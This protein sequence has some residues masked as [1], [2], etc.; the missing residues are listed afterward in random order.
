MNQKQLVKPSAYT[1]RNL[2]EFRNSASDGK[3]ILSFNNTQ[4]Y[5][6]LWS[7]Q[8]T[9]FRTSQKESN[10]TRRGSQQ[11]EKKV[12]SWNQP[13][14]GYSLKVEKQDFVHPK[15]NPALPR[16][17]S[18]C[19]GF[20]QEITWIRICYENYFLDNCYTTEKL[21]IFMNRQNMNIIRTKLASTYL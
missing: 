3:K 18:L 6:R 15:Q 5:S 10:K 1:L 4:L 11:I 19:A 7:Y 14:P 17:Q 20:Y 8:R 2:L 13:L 16:V 9:V 12:R 21:N